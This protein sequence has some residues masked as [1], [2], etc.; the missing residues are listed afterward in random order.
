MCTLK[1][2]LDLPMLEADPV[3]DGHQIR[4]EHLRPPRGGRSYRKQTL[5]DS[6]PFQFSDRERERERKKED[7]FTLVRS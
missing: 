4:P 2:T 1:S 5:C 7:E 3:Q 6:E